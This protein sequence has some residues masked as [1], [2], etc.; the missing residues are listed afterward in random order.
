[1][2]IFQWSAENWES[3]IDY[4][5]GMLSKPQSVAKYTPVLELTKDEGID[6]TLKKNRTW[7]TLSS[8]SRQGTGL[9]DLI[10]PPSSPAKSGRAFNMFRSN[11]GLNGQLS[12]ATAQLSTTGTTTNERDDNLDLDEMFSVDQLQSP[13]RLGGRIQEAIHILG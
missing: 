5:E 13:H 6:R 4:L 9:S 1:M 2:L 12:Q 7:A 10:T 11:S 3:Y 8:F